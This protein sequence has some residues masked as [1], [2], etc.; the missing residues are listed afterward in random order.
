MAWR[1]KRTASGAIKM[2]TRLKALS[3]KIR[4]ASPG[5]RASQGQLLAFEVLEDSRS[6]WK[7]ERY[8]G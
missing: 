6:E 7:R 8:R 1:P 2:V 5:Q 3:V 4:D